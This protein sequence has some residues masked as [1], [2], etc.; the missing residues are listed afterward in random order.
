[1]SQGWCCALPDPRPNSLIHS[2]PREALG[3]QGWNRLWLQELVSFVAFTSPPG[4]WTAKLQEMTIHLFSPLNKEGGSD[5]LTLSTQAPGMCLLL[6]ML[7]PNQGTAGP[8]PE[9]VHQGQATEGLLCSE[10]VVQGSQQCSHQ[11]Q[12]KIN[13]CIE[14][15]RGLFWNLIPG[16]AEGG[17]TPV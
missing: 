12:D 2:G 16:E 3:L 10:T 14:L 15:Y 8:G 4:V 9:K 1:M 13:S 11:L 5:R 17:R 6:P 7:A